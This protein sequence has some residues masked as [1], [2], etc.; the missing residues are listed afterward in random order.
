MTE[1]SQAELEVLRYPLKPG[2]PAKHRAILERLGWKEPMTQ[3]LVDGHWR[4]AKRILGTWE[5]SPWQRIVHLC[6]GKIYRAR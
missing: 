3:E 5:L 6:T 2:N 1:L 4:T